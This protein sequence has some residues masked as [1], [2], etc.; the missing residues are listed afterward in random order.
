MQA[1]MR[2]AG[3][4]RVA[5]ENDAVNAISALV[6]RPGK[7]DGRVHPVVARQPAKGDRTAIGVVEEVV[8]RGSKG[9]IRVLARVDTGAARTSLDTDLALRA[10]L[11]PVFDRVRVRAAAADEPE[12]RDVVDAKI[13]I[14]GREFDVAVAVTDRKDMRYHM[15]VGM[16]ILREAG[17]LVDPSKGNGPEN[18]PRRAPRSS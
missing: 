6:Y 5:S 18:R 12:E 4:K 10:G 7:G 8:I 16:D 1:A 11:G 17:F 3:E 15:V 2:F 14:A 9:D 13:L